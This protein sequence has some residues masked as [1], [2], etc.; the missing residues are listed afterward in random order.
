MGRGHSTECEI[1]GFGEARRQMHFDNRLLTNRTFKQPMSEFQA[2]GRTRL[3]L[4]ALT[5]VLIFLVTC[6]A[7]EKPPRPYGLTPHI[8]ARAYLGLPRRADGVFPP[9]LSQTGAFK[10]V[11]K[12][13]PSESL[14]PYDVIVPFWSD[15]ANKSRWIAIP[16]GKITF[17]PTGEWTF[18]RGTVFVKNFE[19]STDETDP[20]VRRRL[21]TRFLV[22]DSEGGVYGVT[23][24]WRADGSDADLLRASANETIPIK[25]A[26]GDRLQTWY[27]PSREDC[28]TCHTANAGGVLGV[29]T[30]QL[31]RDFKYPS[32]VTDNELRAWNHAGL[33]D[34]KLRETDLPSFAKLAQSGDLTRSLE[35]R[36]RS[37][38]DA[39]CAQCHRPGG[40]VAYFD[41]RYDTPLQ[42]QQLINGP[43]LLDQG[44]DRS[45][46]VVPNDIWRSI[47]YMRANSVD[48]FEMPPLAHEVVDKE[49]MML[50]RQWIQSM[51]G[52]P[53][54]DPPVITPGAGNYDDAVDVTL[55]ESEAGAEIR[56]TLDGTAPTESDLLYQGSITLAGPTV[57]RARAFK[58]GFTRSIIA[59]AVFIIGR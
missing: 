29:K 51:P 44:I 14:I 45:R 21:E 38:L 13:I 15:G 17:A 26:N 28:Q 52:A 54:L 59:Q 48:T 34:H 11:R 6:L 36:A 55:G 18:P 49:S 41:A 7:A 4:F 25:T 23:Y 20:T 58:P 27:Y 57:L 9:L 22:R 32:G 10:D 37:Y 3:C 53:V 56:Y 35:D 43:V 39:N 50:L 42:K 31:N 40:T 8:K 24:K 30:R 46:V 2:R 16:D 5:L 33:F 12:L 1:S 47:L 19:L